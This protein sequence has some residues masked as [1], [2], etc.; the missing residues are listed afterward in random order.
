MN[1]LYQ[2]WRELPDNTLVMDN[3]TPEEFARGHVPGSQNIP[4]G[5]EDAHLEV[6]RGFDRIYLYCRSGRRAQ[7]A[8]SNLNAQGVDQIVC[9]CDCGMPD[10]EKAGYPIES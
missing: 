3:R 1:D 6:L 9:L 8:T 10:W 2:V 7:I 4:Q 5:T